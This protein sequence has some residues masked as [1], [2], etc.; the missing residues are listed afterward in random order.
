[1][2][3]L[4]A[5]EGFSAQTQSRWTFDAACYSQSKM[6]VTPINAAIAYSARSAFRPRYHANDHSRDTVEIELHEMSITDS[7]NHETGL[8]VEG[9]T[10]VP[11]QSAVRDFADKAEVSSVHIAEIEALILAQTGADLA[12]VSSPG[13][14]RFSERSELAGKLDNSLPARFA[15]VDVSDATAAEFATR[16]APPG[17]TVRRFAHYNVWRVI[18]SPP[19]DVPLAVCAADSFAPDDLIAADAVFDMEGQPDWSFEGHVFA[20]HPAHRWHWFSNMTR[21]EALIFKT[22]DSQSGLAHSV[23]HVAFD[24]PE[25]PTDCPPRASIEMRA[26]AYWFE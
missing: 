18:S 17:K 23:P 24:H 20:H 19:Q 26:I 13:V 14:L 12:V 9:F 1:M 5:L 25:V 3:L 22:N 21:D 15:H 2:H 4:E 16:S 6:S 7:R 10:L 8:D 11:H